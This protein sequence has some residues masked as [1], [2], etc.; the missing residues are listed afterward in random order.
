MAL[1]VKSVKVRPKG[2]LKV[3]IFFFL[4]LLIFFALFFALLLIIGGFSLIDKYIE[5]YV[6]FS[7]LTIIL[8][9]IISITTVV[10]FKTSTIHVAPA[11]KV[12]LQKLKETMVNKEGYRIVQEQEHRIIF[13]RSKAFSRIMWLNI[14]KPII[15]IKEDEVLI[16]LNKH[17]QARLT[18]QLIYGKHLEL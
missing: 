6:E 8:P 3:F 16:T 5:M 2:K 1:K 14:D 15:E 17:T 9:F 13:E 4:I 11:D 10:S 18:S 12:N 7:P